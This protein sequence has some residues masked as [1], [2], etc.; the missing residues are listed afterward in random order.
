MTQTAR[1]PK[2]CL[3]PIEPWVTPI[4]LQPV[5]TVSTG[6]GKLGCTLVHLG[7]VSQ[8]SGGSG[9]QGS[10]GW[11]QDSDAAP[12]VCNHSHS[13]LHP[14]PSCQSGPSPAQPSL[15]HHRPSTQ[16]S[17][18]TRGTIHTFITLTS[19]THYAPY[20]IYLRPDLVILQAVTHPCRLADVHS[21]RAP[22]CQPSNLPTCAS[23]SR[24]P[25]PTQHYRRTT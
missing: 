18:I 11:P 22:S 9:A 24:N 5:R 6:C 3:G 1:L 21:F 15:I 19:D 10:A 25:R 23:G 16:A 2:E 13:R 8:R 7:T 12:D 17:F 14:A 4:K 20:S